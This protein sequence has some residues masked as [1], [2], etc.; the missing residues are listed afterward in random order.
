MFFREPLRLLPKDDLVKT[1]P[2]DHAALVYQLHAGWLQK[3]RMRLAVDFLPNRVNRLL[4]IGYGSGILMPELDSHANQ[5]YG[6]D[7]HSLRHE[8]S[9]R[10][11]IHGVHP[12]LSTGTAEEL[13]YE[14]GYFDRI[15]AISSIE[16][17]TDIEAACREMV[18]VLAPGG[19]LVVVMPGCSG[20]VSG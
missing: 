3:A 10:L 13:P 18:R 17:V 6:I 16:F 2:S 12:R 5:L 19:R 1:G 8:V 11:R 4:E 14:N 9:E 20:Q 7:P 15:V